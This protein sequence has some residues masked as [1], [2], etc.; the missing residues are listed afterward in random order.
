MSGLHKVHCFKIRPMIFTFA[1]NLQ[2]NH[3][4]FLF[5][6]SHSFSLVAKKSQSKAYDGCFKTYFSGDFPSPN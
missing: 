1:L 5:F 6:S 2:L 4:P 3:D